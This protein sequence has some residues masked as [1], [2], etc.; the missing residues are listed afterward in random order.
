[1]GNT[2]FF[3]DDLIQKR[4]S[5]HEVKMGPGND[6][7][8]DNHVSI[9]ET[10]PVNEINLTHLTKRKDE[11]NSQVA[12]KMD[13]LERL[14]TRQDSLEREKKALEQLRTN[15]EKYETGKRELL[16]HLEQCLVSFEREEIA[17]NQRLD[18]LQGTQKSFKAMDVELRGLKEAEWPEDSEGY[19]EEL[20]K[21]LALLENM[22][23]DYYKALSRLEALRE[24]KPQ[25]MQE[26]ALMDDALES[27]ALRRRSFG[28]LFVAGL[29]F[30]L[31]LTLAI[32]TLIVFLALRYPLF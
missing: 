2:D 28:E 24:S 13:E 14:R 15:Q 6:P 21:A 12:G 25:K 30:N 1:M 20:A 16:D 22:R 18:L 9:L 11:I 31:P 23:K 3:D 27:D 10:V 5:V 29:A 32:A 19:R 17:L 7:L 8:D 26:H 4:D